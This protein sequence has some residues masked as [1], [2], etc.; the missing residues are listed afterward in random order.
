MLV[1]R[2]KQVKW[3]PTVE[4]FREHMI[5]ILSSYRTIFLRVNRMRTTTV[6]IQMVYNITIYNGNIK[7]QILQ[8]KQ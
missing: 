7:K 3:D 4:E 5:G 2:C 6:H 8:M 1:Q